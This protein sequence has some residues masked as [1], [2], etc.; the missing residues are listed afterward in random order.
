MLGGGTGVFTLGQ[1]TVATL[2]RRIIQIGTTQVGKTA[3]A[4]GVQ[5]I[6]TEQIGGFR[7]KIQIQMIEINGSRY[8]WSSCFMGKYER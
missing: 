1:D 6:Q 3:G 5:E 4:V 2:F 8:V 7:W